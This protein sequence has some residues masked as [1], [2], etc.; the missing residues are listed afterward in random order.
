MSIHVQ[1]GKR[2]HR[3]QVRYRRPDGSQGG[4]TFHRRHDADRFQAEVVLDQTDLWGLSR[5]ERKTTFAEIAQRW[6]QL[7]SKHK[8][9][10][11]QRRDEILRKYLLPELGHMPIRSIKLAQLNDLKVKWENE[12]LAPLTIRNIFG[13]AKPIFRLAAKEQLIISN[14]ASGVELEVKPRRTGRA[15]EP[16]ECRTLLASLDD[17]HRRI[18]Y[19]LLATGLR[20]GELLNMRVG[21]LDLPKRCMAVKMSKTESGNRNIYL[22]DHDVAVLSELLVTLGQEGKDA[23]ALLVRSVTGKPLRYRNLVE[24]VL[25][26]VIK[27]QGMKP[28]TLHDLR[29][30]HATMLVASGNDPKTVQERMGHVDIETT[31]NFYAKT[32]EE[33]RRRATGAIVQFLA[34]EK[35]PEALVNGVVGAATQ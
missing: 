12:N 9:K 27:T 34:Q 32:T 19:I 14:P 30:T 33:G 35:T 18:F 3:Y 22:G 4:R 15:L 20:I 10:T 23:E 26:P 16:E 2:G 6:C 21:D 25:R 29:R 28:F 24:R 1:K 8:P 5:K 7:K 11:A 17:H 31:L 13:I